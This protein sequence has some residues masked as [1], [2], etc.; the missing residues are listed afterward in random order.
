MLVAVDQKTAEP[1][2]KRN[3][4]IRDIFIQRGIH[5]KKWKE[6]CN[7]RQAD[8]MN[9]TGNAKKPSEVPKTDVGKLHLHEGNLIAMKLHHYK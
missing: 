5:L 9:E 8:T 1:C 6:Q 4:S 7:Q 2:N 3:K